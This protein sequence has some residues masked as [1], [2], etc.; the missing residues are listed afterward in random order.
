MNNRAERSPKNGKDQNKQSQSRE[1]ADKKT[2]R[3]R[4][5]WS[6][7]GFGKYR[8]G[9]P[10]TSSIFNNTALTAIASQYIEILVLLL[11]TPEPR[12]APLGA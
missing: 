1:P 6:P 12:S 5:E 4:A 11:P 10:D 3:R 9:I 7:G 8:A 2:I